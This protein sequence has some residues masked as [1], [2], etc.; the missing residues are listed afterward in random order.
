MTNTHKNNIFTVSCRGGVFPLILHL[1]W[2]G[3][4]RNPALLPGESAGIGREGLGVLVWLF[5]G[6]S[7]PYQDSEGAD[8]LQCHSKTLTILQLHSLR[9]YRNLHFYPSLCN[10]LGF[11]FFCFH[12]CL[13]FSSLMGNEVPKPEITYFQCFEYIT[14]SSLC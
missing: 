1:P 12:V 6:L 5:R 2:H 13:G 11:I 3:H 8:K 4:Q 9:C 7:C 10:A 14:F